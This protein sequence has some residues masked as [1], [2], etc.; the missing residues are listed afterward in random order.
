MRRDT[1]TQTYTGYTAEKLAENF[2]DAYVKDGVVY[3]K[4]NDRTPFE[5]MVTDFAE[6]GFV[7]FE[8]IELTNK[9]RSEQNKA[10]MAEY[11]KAQS[12]R[13]QEQ[14]AEERFEARAAMGAGVKMVNVFTGERYTT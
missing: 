6:A 12:N 5:D 9:A 14:I 2:A 10:F 3:W 13:T 8:S 11:T 7:G 1:K 4:S